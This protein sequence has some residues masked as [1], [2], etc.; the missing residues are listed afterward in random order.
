[1]L[2]SAL[3]WDRLLGEKPRFIVVGAVNTLL[4]YLL[5]LALLATLGVWLQSL[6]G[7]SSPIV[8]AISDH[9]YIVV[10]WVAWVVGVP[11]STTT[12]KY[13]AFRSKGRWL[14]QVGRG[15][16]VYLPAQALA[17]ALLW[18][19]VRVLG[20]SPQVGVLIVV[21]ITTV[22]TYIAHKYFTFRV[23]LEVGEVPPEDLL[24]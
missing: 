16:L 8:R 2:R 21:V 13:F 18:L 22:L 5:F 19:T 11:M 4:G 15:Y 1:M 6:S 20:L 7:S 10:Q 23:P 12:M 14:H 17:S 3:S 9:Y 24:D